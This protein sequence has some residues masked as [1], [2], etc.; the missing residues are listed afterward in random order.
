MYDDFVC[1]ALASYM[2]WKY[3][4]KHVPTYIHGTNKQML[5]EIQL[6]EK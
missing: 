1:N 3:L 5:Y 6:T 4:E 2:E